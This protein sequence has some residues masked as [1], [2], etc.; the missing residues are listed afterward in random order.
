MYLNQLTASNGNF[1]LTKP[2]A[3]RVA[4]D[5]RVPQGTDNNQLFILSDTVTGTDGGCQ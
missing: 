4:S 5:W 2:A 1:D 3:Q